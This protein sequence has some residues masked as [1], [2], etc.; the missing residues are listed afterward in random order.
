MYYNA[1]PKTTRRVNWNEMSSND[2]RYSWDCKLLHAL[3]TR[4]DSKNPKENEKEET[5]TILV[6]LCGEVWSPSII[7]CHRLFFFRGRFSKPWFNT[8]CLFINADASLVYNL[9]YLS[10]INVSI[11]CCRG[12]IKYYLLTEWIMLNTTMAKE[13]LE[14]LK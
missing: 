12:L 6:Y 8:I 14:K 3:V 7:G 4:M 9:F 10:W 5:K 2:S 1:R 11:Y 13:N